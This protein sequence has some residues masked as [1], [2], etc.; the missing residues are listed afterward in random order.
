MLFSVDE[1]VGGRVESWVMPD[2]PAVTSRVIVDFD[3]EHHVVI[4]AFVYRP[5]LKQNGLH[6]TGVCGFALDDNNGLAAAN[7]LQ[8]FD[9]DTNLLLYRRRPDTGITDKRCTGWS[10]S[11]FARRRSTTCF[12]RASAWASG[13]RSLP[14]GDHPLDPGTA[15]Y[16]I[17]LRV[18]SRVLAGLETAAP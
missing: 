12:C 4:E 8:I 15:L 18:G 5:L 9:A 7:W 2:N 17:D 16:T 11:S 3:A 10:R 1:D 6:N 14:R 13:A